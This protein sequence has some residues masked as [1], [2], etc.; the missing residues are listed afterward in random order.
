MTFFKLSLENQRKSLK[1]YSIY[2]VTLIL[3]VCIFYIFNAIDAQTAM[4]EVSKT[5]SDVIDTMNTALSIMSIVVSFILGFLIVYASRFLIK[6]RKRE[7]GIYMTLGMHKND[8][9]GILLFETLMIGAISLIVGLIIGIALS[10]FMSLFVANMFQANMERFVFVVS[11]SAIGKTALYYV[12]I[13]VIVL[14][15]NTIVIRKAKLIDLMSAHQKRERQGLRNLPMCLAIFI[16]ACLL[17][18]YAY[19]HVTVRMEDLTSQYD[20][21]LQM[22]LGIAGTL[23]IFWSVSGLAVNLL[24]KMPGIYHKKLNSF[25]MGEV[26]H[27]INTMVVAGSII[28]L[29]LF[30][31]ICVLSS[32]FTLKSYKENIVEELAP[33]SASISKNMESV[34]EEEH[35]SVGKKSYSAE[36][37]HNSAGE[38]NYSV[39]DVL[40]QQNLDLSQFQDIVDVYTYDCD[41]VTHKTV[42]GS[43]GDVILE[44]DSS[45]AFFMEQMVPVIKVSDYNQAAAIY[46]K[47]QL[48]LEEDE[49]AIVADYDSMVHFFNEGLKEN[50]ELEVKGTILHEKYGECQDGFLMMSYSKQN[51]GLIV[52]PDM[53]QFSEEERVTNYYLVNYRDKKT[54]VFEA[55]GSWE[56]TLNPSNREWEALIVST[57][58]DIYDDS[59]GSS[60][61]VVFVALYLGIVFMISGSAILALKEMSD[62]IDSR[63]KYVIL[64]KIGTNDHEINRALLKQ[65]GLFFGFP[66]L[67][68]VIHSIFGIQV[69]NYMLSVYDSSDILGSLAASAA[70]IVVIYG[71]YFVVSYLCC[72]RLIR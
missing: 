29:L 63:N 54:E 45:F 68:A 66:L 10:Q 3:G 2:F 40:R 44:K 17:L 19:Y 72:R 7:F 30:C 14:L 67:V 71:G 51:M 36:G 47:K 6:K 26:S 25:I 43:Y 58:T 60:G 21:L 48:S 12:L 33:I 22:V 56:E 35:N 34:G 11:W 18:G 46:G 5:K 37:E 13:Y 55:G 28:C 53:I 50:R 61:M 20:V 16:L 24:K 52:V 57:R 49:Y 39:E 64:R 42:L 62:A 70:V 38:K 1:D 32:A 65:M 31:T 27:Q 4:M 23:L 8:I 15:M 69:C 41:S 9:S 59:I